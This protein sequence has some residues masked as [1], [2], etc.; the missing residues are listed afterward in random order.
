MESPG[1]ADKNSRPATRMSGEDRRAQI[2]DVASTLF[3]RR[4][5]RG[6]TTREIAVAA[7][8]NEAIIFR[9]FATK[10]EL[11]AAI[12]DRKAELSEMRALQQVMS[13]AMAARDDRRVFESLAFFLLEFH[14][15]DETAMRLLM[16]SAL[17]GH[18]L[19]QMI[20]RNHI[21][22]MHRMLADYVE[23]RIADGAF[24]R[25]DGM[26][27]SRAFMGMIINHATLNRFFREQAE[28]LLDIGNQETA[29]RF[30]DLILASLTNP[31]ET[32]AKIKTK[33]GK[34]LRTTRSRP[35]KSKPGA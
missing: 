22:R 27:V 2:I 7:G 26:T 16:Y 15:N 24:R 23:S 1:N 20:F 34:T 13:E 28:A 4:G 8:V 9:H 21:S 32:P 19:A 3:S 29:S 31:W 12:I 6:T 33:P 5:F 17:E 30:T 18:E 10:S 11:Y 14:Q 25:V 35:G